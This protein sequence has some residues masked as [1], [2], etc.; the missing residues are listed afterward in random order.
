MGSVLFLVFQ[1]ALC[2]CVIKVIPVLATAAGGLTAGKEAGWSLGAGHIPAQTASRQ[3]CNGPC[4]CNF[5]ANF[6]CPAGV[7]VLRDGCNCCLMCAKQLGEACEK[8]DRCDFHKR[9][10]CDLGTPPNR[11]TGVCKSRRAAP[12]FIQNKAFKHGETMMIS[13]GMKCTCKNRILICQDLCQ[14]NI[15]PPSVN[16]PFPRKVKL[17]GK[18]CAEWVCEEPKELETVDTTLETSRLEGMVGPDPAMMR[19][20]CQVQT[21]EWSACSKTCGTGISFRTT[22]DNAECKLEKQDRFCIMRPCQAYLEKEIKEGNKCIPSKR[23]D[24]PIKF[25]IFGC[26]SVK[27]YHMTICGVCTDG[28]CCTPNRTT[29]MA[30]E[31]RCP[32]GEITEK[33]MMFIQDCTCHNNCPVRSNIFESP[34]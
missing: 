6:S 31:F 26:T 2:S 12:C 30:V 7:S 3:N 10:Y 19:P 11:T 8:P 32:I 18:C 15:D 14:K 5:T 17:P 29:T 28:R 13:C 20:K 27:A 34:Q 23:I 9:L 4:H 16:C 21:T 25:H 24:F 33:S 22:N 1:L